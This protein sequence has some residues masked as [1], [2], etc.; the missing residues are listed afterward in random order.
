S[1]A[2]IYSASVTDIVLVFCF[3]LDVSSCSS[4][5]I[6]MPSGCVQCVSSGVELNEWVECNVFT[7][8]YDRAAIKFRGVDADINFNISDYQEDMNQTIKN[9]S[10]EDFVHI[11]RRHGN[12]FSRGGSKYRGVPGNKCDGYEAR[13]APFVGNKHEGMKNLSVD[14][15]TGFC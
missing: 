4:K 10:K 8:A 6:M 15:V 13:M 12:G 5:F 3:E 2:A 7:G 9:L 14:D 11:L 1:E